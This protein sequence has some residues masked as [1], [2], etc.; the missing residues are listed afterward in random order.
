MQFNR[1]KYKEHAK[2]VYRTHIFEA[3]LAGIVMWL[4]T[5]DSYSRVELQTGSTTEISNSIQSSLVNPLVGWLPLAV[6]MLF[7]L[8]IAIYILFSP[9]ITMAV[10]YLKEL[11]DGKKNPDALAVVKKGVFFRV[12][13]VT[14]IRNICVTL[15]LLLFVAP[16]VYLDYAWRYV[17][18]IA[19]EEPE[20]SI[21]EIFKKSKSLVY[22]YKFDLFVLDISFFGW[23]LLSSFLAVISFGILGWVSE[24][25]LLPYMTLTDVF[26]YKALIHNREENEV[27]EIVEE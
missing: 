18:I 7:L 12:A 21:T 22:G 24:I 4:F 15:G 14:I 25:L 27:I 6:G 19:I 9:I 2:K 23:V 26:A 11:A 16:G 17:G 13:A 8:S 1:A 20:L 5:A 10:Y 3:I